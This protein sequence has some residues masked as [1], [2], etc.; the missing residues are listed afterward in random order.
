MSSLPHAEARSILQDAW[1]QLTGSAPSERELSFVQSIALMETGY[2]RIGQFEK[3]AANGQYNW[4]ALEAARLPD[5]SCKAGMVP[6][7]DSGKQVC[8]LAFDSDVKAAKAYL[9]NLIS[10]P[11]M[12]ARTAATRAALAT[13]DALAV[14]TA[15]KTSLGWYTTSIEAYRDMIVNGLKAIGAA[16]PAA[17]PASAGFPWAY[18]ALGIG[19]AAGAFWALKRFGGKK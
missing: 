10:N 18:A 6:G 4:G 5:G 15:M 9:W 2:G 11:Y 19:G 12:A 16:P 17:R 3:F 1:T 8:F 7:I 13:G 14:A